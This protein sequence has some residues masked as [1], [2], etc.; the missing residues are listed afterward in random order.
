LTFGPSNQCHPL[1]DTEVAFEQREPGEAI[2]KVKT[3][4]L[5]CTLHD[6]RPSKAYFG[7]TTFKPIEH[8]ERCSQCVSFVGLL[9][10]KDLKFKW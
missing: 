3:R 2:L 9:T 4:R 1:T 7:R 5:C 10:T 6:E 8:R